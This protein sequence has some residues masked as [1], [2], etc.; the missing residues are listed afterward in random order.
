MKPL[1]A[2]AKY[3]AFALVSQIFMWFVFTAGDWAFDE[4]HLVQNDVIVSIMGY[5]T[6]AVIA[7]VPVVAYFCLK[8]KHFSTENKIADSLLHIIIWSANAFIITM[9]CWSLLSQDKWIVAQDY[10]HGGF[11]DLNGI[12]Y[13]LIPIAQAFVAAAMA[14]F[15][16]LPAIIKAIKNHAHSV[17]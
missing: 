3:S 1:R 14:L 9:P 7:F 5:V 2:Y 10:I 4:H 17:R 6:L 16:L 13:L 15:S 8:Q 11:I 12:E